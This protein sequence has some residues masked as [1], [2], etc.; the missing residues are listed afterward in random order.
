MKKNTLKKVFAS[1]T[2]S[3]VAAVSVTA[4]TASAVDWNASITDMNFGATADEI[5]AL[6]DEDKVT[7]SIDTKEAKPGDS[8]TL[9][10]STNSGNWSALGIHVAYDNALT[11]EKSALSNSILLS[12]LDKATTKNPFDFT[13]LEV[14]KKGVLFGASASY[15]FGADGTGEIASLTFTVPEDA[16][17]GDFY[18]VS[19]YIH[20][21]E[22]ELQNEAGIASG[23]RAMQA[24]T[25]NN[26]LVDGGIQIA[27]E[28]TTT[29]A[30]TTTA[31][32]TTTT[33]AKPVTPNKPGSTTPKATTTPKK[34]TTTVAK[35]DSPKTGVSGVGVAA[36]GL[37][38]AAT[39]A[40][41]LRKKED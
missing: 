19:F 29:T 3:A 32:E 33:T 26:G 5:A 17:P 38:A 41:V 31:P 23:S 16:Q 21:N 28:E 6:S 4:V 27:A 15:N 25:F 24:W 34:T 7:L 12:E 14:G 1:L 39:A 13:T 22:D 35:K 8:V 11:L 9:S 20:N 18:P 37:V 40:F 30:E 36:A 10:V 2:L